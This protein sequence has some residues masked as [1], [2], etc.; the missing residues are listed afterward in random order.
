MSI[1]MLNYSAKTLDDFLIWLY[2]INAVKIDTEKGFTLKLHE[3]DP[4]APLSLLYF[5]LRI[6]ENKGGPLTFAEVQRIAQL[7]HAYLAGNNIGYDGI[8]PVPHAG[9][10]FAGELQEIV[11]EQEMR[12]VPLLTLEKKEGS[13]GRHIGMLLKTQDLPRG[14]R[15]LLIDDLITRAGSKAE[16]VMSLRDAGYIVEDCIV[17]LD[18][19]QGGSQGMAALGVTLHSIASLSSVLE[20]Y[21]HDNLITV[22]QYCQIRAYLKNTS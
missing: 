5:N 4:A 21:R 17:F 7:F 14:C 19:E 16:A 6:A 20:V 1:G 3:S 9:T 11:Y 18:R 15:V 2:Q 8:C 13:D 22:A 10:P 12:T